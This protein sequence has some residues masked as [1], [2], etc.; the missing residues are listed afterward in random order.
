[1]T[2]E[3]L[4]DEAWST[5]LYATNR[6]KEQGKQQYIFLRASLCVSPDCMFLCS[7]KLMRVSEVIA[8]MKVLKLRLALPLSTVAQACGSDESLIC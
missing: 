8:Q 2:C 3:K 6:G 7:P 1:V 4:V 5:I